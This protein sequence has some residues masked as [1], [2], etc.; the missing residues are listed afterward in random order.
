VSDHLS[1]FTT[2]AW[3]GA[4]LC[5]GTLSIFGRFLDAADPVYGWGIRGRALG[6]MCA[7][8]GLLIGLWLLCLAQ[9]KALPDTAGVIT[10]AP[11]AE[12]P[13]SALPGGP[14]GRIG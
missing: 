6:R 8:V 10:L 13:A 11:D 4:F 3:P 1:C 14:G 12:K 5:V 7:I 2:L 9:A